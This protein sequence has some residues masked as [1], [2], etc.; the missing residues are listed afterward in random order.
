[1]S[2]A[3]EP[4]RLDIGIPV[5]KETMLQSLSIFKTAKEIKM[6]QLVK[7]KSNFAEQVGFAW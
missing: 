2:G 3:A 1:M 6:A 5:K 4:K 7:I